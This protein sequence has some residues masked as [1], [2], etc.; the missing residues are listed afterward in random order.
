M[1]SLY[2]SRGCFKF[3]AWPA[4]G[5]GQG[6]RRYAG[7]RTIAGCIKG[8]GADG[9]VAIDVFLCLSRFLRFDI[10]YTFC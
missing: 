5:R 1:P 10:R 7:T 8:R 9:L 2:R 6:S 4:C 3:E